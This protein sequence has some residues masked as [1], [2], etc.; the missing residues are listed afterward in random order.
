MHPIKRASSYVAIAA[1][2]VLVAGGSVRQ[3]NGQAAAPQLDYQTFKEKVEPVFLKKREGHARCVVC[4]TINNAPFHL[5]PLS[6]GAT[7]WNEQQS[8]QNFDLV[9]KVAVPGY[10]E[11]RILK[12]PLA[13]PAGD[14]HH[15]G[16]QQFASENDPDWQTLKA[17]V[18]G[19]K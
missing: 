14:G 7:T 1:C 12:H 4:H 2:L 6:P 8:R 19:A 13:A 10:E 9:Q 16:G 15:G 5:V 18:M 17:W 3:A 11:S